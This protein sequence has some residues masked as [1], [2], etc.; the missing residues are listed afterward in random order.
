MPA[1]CQSPFTRASNG[2]GA[3]A[4]R[5]ARN[6]SATSSDATMHASNAST[7]ANAEVHRACG[8]DE[9]GVKEESQAEC[10]AAAGGHAGTPAPSREQNTDVSGVKAAG[11]S[12]MGAGPAEDVKG[13]VMF[14]SLPTGGV[15]AVMQ[16]CWCNLGVDV[17]KTCD[18]SLHGPSP[19][20]SPVVCRHHSIYISN[21]ALAPTSI[22]HSVQRRGA[23]LRSTLGS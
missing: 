11:S 4:E 16:S 7:V 20:G 9:C 14:A 8:R 5:A 21:A 12:A 15:C 19:A 23:A 2:A 18:C 1:A 17:G 3:A 6:G 10:G 22:L 13:M